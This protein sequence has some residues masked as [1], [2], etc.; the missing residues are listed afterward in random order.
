[1]VRLLFDDRAL[2]V[3][4]VCY[5][6]NPDELA[7]AHSGPD[8]AVWFDDSVEL[9]IDPGHT[10]ERYLQFALNCT[11]ATFDRRMEDIGW[12]D[13][14]S[15]GT[16]IGADRW[17]A[18]VQIPFSTLGCEPPEAG[19]VFSANFCRNRKT[20]IP[21]ADE[22]GEWSCWA[23]V[24]S[25]YHEPSRFGHVIFAEDAASVPLQALARIAAN[26][27]CTEGASLTRIVRLELPEGVVSYA[28]HRARAMA[29]LTGEQSAV[30]RALEEVGHLLGSDR[31]DDPKLRANFGDRH[32]SLQAE[33]ERLREQADTD[34]D[35]AD[36]QQVQVALTNLTSR[37]EQLLWDARFELLFAGL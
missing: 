32:A 37:A 25:D 2:Y 36:L 21:G 9:F 1:V 3:G 29:E 7:H 34:T 18:E 8:A 28:P 5:E 19:A 17:T 30:A 11:G 4:F 35:A 12:T 6:P 22:H 27:A 20:S 16:R 31:W 23:P 10:H 14:W 24:Q 26:P 33:L 13:E 15:V